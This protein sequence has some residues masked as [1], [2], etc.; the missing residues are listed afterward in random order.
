MCWAPWWGDIFKCCESRKNIDTK[1]KPIQ[2]HC[3]CSSSSSTF[4][5]HFSGIR[6]FRQLLSQLFSQMTT[7]KWKVLIS[8]K[9]NLREM[10]MWE[11][12]PQNKVQWSPQTPPNLSGETFRSL[13][14]ALGK[15]VCEQRNVAHIF[16]IAVVEVMRS[17]VGACRGKCTSLFCIN[18]RVSYC[19]TNWAVFYWAKL[20]LREDRWWTPPPLPLIYTITSPDVC[21]TEVF[22]IREWTALANPCQE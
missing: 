12:R 22:P 14:S 16:A 15:K 3:S 18:N 6:I 11:I 9:Y 2:C 13:S 10:N 5:E 17:R 19:C 7:N 1:L 4:T 21:F 8:S 20:F